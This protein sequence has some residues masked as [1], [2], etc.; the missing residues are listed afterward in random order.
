MPRELDRAPDRL[1][2]GVGLEALQLLL[3]PLRLAFH[4]R[5]AQER[6]PREAR[7]P[8]AQVELLVLLGHVKSLSSLTRCSRCFGARHDRVE[9]A[10]AQV[11][12]GEPEVLRQLLARRLLHDARA[13]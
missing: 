2:A 6:Q 8:P 10:E 5:A 13:R 1:V 9:V 7:E 3:E 4:A 12:L 11:L